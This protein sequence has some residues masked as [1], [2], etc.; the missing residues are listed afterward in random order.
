[1]D[2]K[3]RVL[4][5]SVSPNGQELCFL[6]GKPVDGGKKSI[7][8]INTAGTEPNYTLKYVE[9]VDDKRFIMSPYD[10]DDTEDLLKELLDDYI[11]GVGFN[12]PSS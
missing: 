5:S 1:M 4:P 7:Y 8:L 3:H 9:F 12:A 11:R 6:A 2:L 10:G